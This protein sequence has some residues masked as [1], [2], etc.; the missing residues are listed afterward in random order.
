MVSQ[1]CSPEAFAQS[2]AQLLQTWTRPSIV[3][4]TARSPKQALHCFAGLSTVPLGVMRSE[5][6]FHAAGSV[7]LRPL[8]RFL[9]R[10]WIRRLACRPPV[11]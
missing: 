4:K 1:F 2:L 7:L 9:Y 3:A 8:Y 11:W 10:A 6:V 5:W